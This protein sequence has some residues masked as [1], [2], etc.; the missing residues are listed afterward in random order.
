[1]EPTAVEDAV[2]VVM[3]DVAMKTGDVPVNLAG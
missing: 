2:R 3:V 1:M